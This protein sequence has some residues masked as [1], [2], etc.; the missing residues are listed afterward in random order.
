MVIISLN[1]CIDTSIR[2]LFGRLVPLGL[3]GSPVVVILH[4]DVGNMY[5]YISVYIGI[6]GGNWLSQQGPT[7]RVERDRSPMAPL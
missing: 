1:I 6:G 5:V 4:N 3:V 2:S 7:C